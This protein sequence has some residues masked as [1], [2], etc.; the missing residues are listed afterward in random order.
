M[1]T[2]ENPGNSYLW[3]TTFMTGLAVG[4][5]D[6]LNAADPQRTVECAIGIPWEPWEFIE[7]A[8][9]HG[10]PK[11]FVHGVPK[12]LERTI[13]WIVGGET[14]CN[15]AKYRSAVAM[16][17]TSRAAE[18]RDQ[19]EKLKDDMPEHCKQILRKMAC[20]T[21]YYDQRSQLW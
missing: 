5:N 7:Q 18:L 10:H 6:V 2:I 21:G 13:Q 16:K 12:P 1:C 4:Y 8:K 15:I 3:S 20:I 14:P 17:W 9:G 19:E 11:L